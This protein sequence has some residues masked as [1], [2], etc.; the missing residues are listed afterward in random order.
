MK[1]GVNYKSVHAHSNDFIGLGKRSRTTIGSYNEN[2]N[3]GAIIKEKKPRAPRVKVLIILYY[4]Y[5]NN[6][7]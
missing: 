4:I 1:K 2:Y 5:K 3:S 6:N 7:K